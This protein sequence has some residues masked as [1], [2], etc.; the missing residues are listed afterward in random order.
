MR[1]IK[2]YP[3]LSSNIVLKPV[4]N[5]SYKVIFHN[6]SGVN[7]DIEI[8]ESTKSVLEQC[9]GF[10]SVRQLVNHLHQ[11]FNL[12]SLEEI[13]IGV[14]RIIQDLCEAN[15]LSISSFPIPSEE[16]ILKAPGSLNAVY[17]ELTN[18]C[19]L[20]CIHCYNESGE[21]R[22]GELSTEEMLSAINEL[23]KIGV[24]DVI[25]TGGEPF[26][27]KDIFRLIKA[28]EH[29]HIR[30]SIFS[31]GLLITPEIAHQL[32]KYNVQFVA[33]S[34]D[35]RDPHFFSPELSRTYRF[36]ASYG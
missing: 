26:E 25:L 1:Q 5:E 30:F 31:N 10:R 22:S 7:S 6:S 9:D 29:N 16:L 18:K 34:L 4:E 15:I 21:M 24:T 17:I 13:Q 36:E 27:R 23:G 3:Y 14:G 20:Q 33:I 11:V 2:G 8:N 12:S 28:L 19:N 32:R 35:L